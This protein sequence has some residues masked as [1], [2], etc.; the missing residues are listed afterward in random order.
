MSIL[1]LSDFPDHEPSPSDFDEHHAGWIWFVDNDVKVTG[2][3]IHPEPSTGAPAGWC[4]EKALIDGDETLDVTLLLDADEGA[5]RRAEV[6]LEMTR[7]GW[8]S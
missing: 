4:I 2:R 8:P 1:A 7:A 6:A 3:W 5:L